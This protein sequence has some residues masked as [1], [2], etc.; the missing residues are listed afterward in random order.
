MDWLPGKLIEVL[1][2]AIQIGNR[3]FCLCVD[4][5][6]VARAVFHWA[7]I[8]NELPRNLLCVLE[9]FGIET[10]FVFDFP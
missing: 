3:D 10:I 6:E 9:L 8:G 7:I 5:H 1:A 4:Q 2:V